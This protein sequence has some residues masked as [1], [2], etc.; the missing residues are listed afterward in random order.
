MDWGSKTP[1]PPEMPIKPGKTSQHHNWPRYMDWPQIGP[2][3]AKKQG[4]ITPKGQMVPI[5]R[6]HAGGFHTLVRGTMFARNGAV[7]PG[8]S[9]ECDITF[10]VKGRPNLCDNRVTAQWRHA[11]C[12]VSPYFAISLAL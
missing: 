5:S 8:Q 2:N 7:T 4:E 12:K 11:G 6:A 3:I 1:K 10:F 9:R